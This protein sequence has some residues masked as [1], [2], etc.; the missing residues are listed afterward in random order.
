MLREI[1]NGLRDIRGFNREQ[2]KKHRY[3]LTRNKLVF[4]HSGVAI[5]RVAGVLPEAKRL[6][7][8]AIWEVVMNR[9]LPG[10]LLAFLLLPCA[11]AAQ[12]GTT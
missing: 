9:N 7:Q 2:S 10:I 5:V 8:S 11:A 3:I 12:T 4:R 1:V 6:H